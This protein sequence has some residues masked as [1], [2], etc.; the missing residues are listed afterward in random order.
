MAFIN[1]SKIKSKEI[2][3]GF[4]GRF[5]HSANTTVAHWDVKKGST[6]PVHQHVNE[7]IVNVISG[8]LELTVGSEKKIMSAGMCAVIPANVPHTASALT[9]CHLIDVFYPVRPEYN[10]E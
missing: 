5:I 3:P 9:D 7:M 2:V 6:I 4:H 1:L 10:N 8:E